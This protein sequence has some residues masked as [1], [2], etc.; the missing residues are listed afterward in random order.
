MD[1]AGPAI[2]VDIVSD[3]VCPWCIIGYRQLELALSGLGIGAWVRWHPFELNPAMGPEGQDLREHVAEKYGASSEASAAARAKITGLGKD[4][5]FDFAFSEN[6][7]IYN[8]FAAH[9]LLAW[10]A[11]QRA[12]H[13]LKMALFSAYFSAGRNISDMDVLVEVAA[14]AGLDA[15]AAREVLQSGSHAQATRAELNGWIERGVTGVPAVI[16]DRK[17]LLTGAQGTQGYAQ[18]LQHCLS[19]RAAAG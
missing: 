18:A 13:P 19:Q 17:V 15:D 14:S 16:L 5:G 11:E 2:E 6:S 12:Q 10:A 4:L 1:T 3:V 9:Q 8:T 7:R